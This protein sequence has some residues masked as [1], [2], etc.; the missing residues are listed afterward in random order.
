MPRYLTMV[1]IDESVVPEGVPSQALIQRMEVLMKEM[2]EAGVLLETA[3]L[4]RTQEGTR[5]TNSG[6]RIRM[7]D[8]PFTEAKEVVGGYAIVR[9]ADRAEALEWG[10]RFI[11]VH[12]DE[13]VV[14]AEIREIEDPV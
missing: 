11:E 6:G 12:E 8:G 14:T 10:R 2:T 9:V 4:H 7:F 5:I 1:R 3:G 13:V